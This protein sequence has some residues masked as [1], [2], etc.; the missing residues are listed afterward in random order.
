MLRDEQKVVVRVGI[1][2]I[3]MRLNQVCHISIVL[4]PCDD[5]HCHSH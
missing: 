2:D 5:T 3:A 1:G 4:A